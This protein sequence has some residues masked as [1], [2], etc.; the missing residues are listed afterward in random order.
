MHNSGRVLWFEK[1][2]ELSE[3]IFHRVQ[4]VTELIS[5]L[6]HHSLE[7]EWNEHIVKFI[8]FTYKHQ[9]VEKHQFKSF[10]EQFTETG[11]LDE[12]LLFYLLGNYSKFP[13]DIGIEL[14]HTFYIV[15]GPIERSQRDA[16]IVPYFANTFMDESWKADGYLQLRLDIVFEGL[17]LPQYVYQLMTVVVLNETFTSSDDIEVAKNGATIRHGENTTYFIHD[18]NTRHVTVQVSTSLGLLGRSW[19][20]LLRVTKAIL[21]LLAKVWKACRAEV[22]LYCAHCLLL[23]AP[24]PA[25]DVSPHWLYTEGERDQRHCTSELE[26]VPCRRRGPSQ[27]P[28][29]ATIPKVLKYPCKWVIRVLWKR[30]SFAK[31]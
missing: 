1:A 24:T 23:K 8:P 11:V 30:N 9:V 4:D 29:V 2:P 5:L 17:A 16:Y 12:A 13:V 15:H 19:R 31:L 14:L 27:K 6:F 10:T 20:E 26:F 18:Y 21:D 22:I 25:R 3:Y 7:E 28:M